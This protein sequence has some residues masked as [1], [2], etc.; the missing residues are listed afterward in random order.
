MINPPRLYFRSSGGTFLSLFRM[1]LDPMR[2]LLL[3]NFEGG[4]DEVYLGLEP[5]YFDDPVHGQG[6]AVVAYR[7]DQQIDVYHQPGVRLE[8]AHYD[9]VGKGLAGLHERSMDGA[10]FEIHESGVDAAFAFEDSQGRAIAVRIE[11]TGGAA[12]RPFSLLAPLGAGVQRPTRFPLFLLY[13]FDFV[14]RSGTHFEVNIAGRR[15]TPDTL[16]VRIQG[17]AVY[18][19]RYSSDPCLLHWNPVYQGKLALQ[20]PGGKGSYEYDGIQYDLSDN[21]GVLE[22]FGMRP[23]NC[24]HEVRFTFNPAFPDI[25]C[26]RGGEK[27]QGEFTIW[28]EESMGRIGGSY[29]VKRSGGQVEI[30]MQPRH[31][32]RPGRLS[33]AVGL[34]VNLIPV[35]RNWPRR[36]RWRAVVDVGEDSAM[37]K[38]GW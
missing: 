38:A 25:R 37:M 13:G 19:S 9:F 5:Q 2:R 18:F 29:Q 30:E 12:R 22:I 10:R 33:G 11:E 16:P 32:W 1:Q 23:A 24:P 21:R 26:M 4:R 6:L 35:F 36:Y 14:R 15:I 34:M 20:Q 31:G 28:L 27:V 7:R 3:I 17:Q 8:P